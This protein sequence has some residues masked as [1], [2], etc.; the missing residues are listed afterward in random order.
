MIKTKRRIF[1]ICLCLLFLAPAGYLGYFYY[2]VSRDAETRIR[3]GAIDRIIS[4]ESPV[5]YDDG[6]TPIG[7]FFEK[8]HRKYIPY[9]EIP[10]D[11]VNALVAAEDR[12]FFHHHGFDFKAILRAFIA[13]LRA[14]KVVQ[15]GSTL[16]QQTA[17]NIF[18]R[19][20]RSYRAKLKELIQAFLFER[21]YTKQDILEMY[22]NQFF[23][24]GYGKG[25]GIAARYFFGKEAKDLDL[26]ESAFIA[27]SVKG[28]NRYNP[29]IKK[30]AA[31]KEAARRAAKER[32]DYVLANM[33]RLHFITRDRYLKARAREVPFREGKITY[34]LNVVLDY[35]RDQLES[36]YFRRILEEQGIENPATSGMHIYTSVNREMQESALK[37]IRTRLPLMDVRLNGLSADPTGERYRNFM[38]R[39]GPDSRE[40][41]VPF[42][43]RV[44]QVAADGENSRMVVS[45]AEGGGII[46]YAGLRAM[47]E[48]W[49]KWKAGNWATFDSRHVRAFLQN[50]RPGDL[51]PVQRVRLPGPPPKKR[52]V[53]S[54][55][56][57]LEGGIVVLHHGMVK[58]MVGG[59]FNRFFNRAVD[60]RRQLGSIFKPIL[61]T[62]ALQLGW[63]PLDPL[64]NRRDIFRFEQTGYV[65]RP[66]HTPKSDTVSMAWAGA[67]SEN[68]ATV[69]LL[70]HL[71]DR[72][73]PGQF[74]E[75]TD[76]VGLSQR[77][78]ESYRE[79]KH[80][81]RDR[82]GVVVNRRA[83]MEAA[84]E[85][86]VKELESDIIFTGDMEML[87][88]VRRLHYRVFAQDLKAAGVRKADILKYDF[89]RLNAQNL[90]MRD[91]F[92]RLMGLL[93][94]PIS[95]LTPAEIRRMVRLTRGF[96]RLPGAGADAG[97]VYTEHPD[98]LSRGEVPVTAEWLLGR[99]AP[100]DRRRIRIE[101]ILTSGI[102]DQIRDALKDHYLQL[103]AYPRYDPQVLR[104][105]RDFRTLV[106]L[107]YVVFLARELGISAPL[108]RVL[109]FPL[110]PD[111][112]SIME[113]ALAY[114]SIMS[115]RTYPLGAGPGPEQV[116]I[117]T[118]ITDREGE[119]LWQYHP[120]PRRVVSDRV[121][122]LVTGI[123]QKVM[124][125]GTGRKARE[126]VRVFG[127]P[128]PLFGKTGT[129]SRF[130][131]SSFIGFIPSPDARSGGFDAR[132]GYVIA[133]Y[134][135]YD[136]NRSMKGKHFA[137]YGSSGAL[138]LWIDTANG[139]TRSREYLGSLQPADVVFEPPSVDLTGKD[140]NLRQVPVSPV[141]GLPLTLPPEGTA[142]ADAQTVVSD[143]AYRR[144]TWVLGRRFEPVERR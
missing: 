120:A 18:R 61:Y 119:T 74:R 97:I 138:P 19:E 113:G 67:R 23:V 144:D 92:E 107:S 15:G 81:I 100:P 70:Y 94:R 117:I 91:R 14:G 118:R 53:L 131:N 8:T 20:K 71:T 77:P 72:L 21:R 87:D 123:L 101:G 32:K 6:K 130:T 137:V 48:A 121:S 76:L 69:W 73:N 115:G 28:P 64:Q 82:W 98:A 116:P 40:E 37:S 1:L 141:T 2:T 41:N 30:S 103:A 104:R 112:I 33:L 96:Y 63:N 51:V 62:A 79:Y 75:I 26:V 59:F 127:V 54:G 5:Y 27:G 108:A 45:W 46:D 10:A 24:T 56:P 9:R 42:L 133:A 95:D 132:D 35:V 126:A 43:A 128:I 65:P 142:P 140:D 122:I 129:A 47:G 93:D 49:I 111:S 124:D 139:I 11:F 58:A 50:F 17:K 136:D 134:V 105:I 135:G 13:N 55:I 52:L 109:S 16:T 86:A 99:P 85:G 88:A 90:N 34:R 38:G 143:A 83:L 80:R 22:A 60:A 110:G 12:N 44:S 25:L 106:S 29:F 57:E 4:S 114:Q 3:R 7:V 102:L 84:F 66:D 78:D 68:L 125:I 39:E 89:T 36:D 31:E